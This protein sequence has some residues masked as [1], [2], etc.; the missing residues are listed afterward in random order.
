MMLRFYNLQ[1]ARLLKQQFQKMII[2]IQTLKSNFIEF[3]SFEMLNLKNVNAQSAN[4]QSTIFKKSN[5]TVAIDAL[6]SQITLLFKLKII[7]F[8]KIKTYKSQNENKH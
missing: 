2:K 7:K 8:E 5:A 3:E 4:V 1:R 6:L